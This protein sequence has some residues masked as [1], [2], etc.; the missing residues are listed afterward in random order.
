ME[1]FIFKCFYLLLPAYFSNMAPVIFKNVLNKLAIPV[2]LGKKVNGKEMFGKNKTYRGLIVGTLSGILIA[3]IQKVLYVNGIIQVSF[4]DFS[5]WLA[6]GFL[7]GLGA[8]LGDLIESFAKRQFNIKSGSSFKPWDQ[9]D[10]IVGAILLSSFVFSYRWL[11]I[12]TV[13][14]LTFMLH[15]LVNHLAFYLHIRKEKW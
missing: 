6:I 11:I 2:D 12:V 13:L 15:I 14:I 10:F 4:I 5:N 1:L 8:M 9:I 7:M 3:Y